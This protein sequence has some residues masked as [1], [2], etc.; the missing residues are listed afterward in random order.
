MGAYEAYVLVFTGILA[1]PY[2]V[3]DI[4]PTDAQK[5]AKPEND[6]WDRFCCI[7]N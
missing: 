1:L 7:D 2:I 6:C 4:L 5:Y 3:L